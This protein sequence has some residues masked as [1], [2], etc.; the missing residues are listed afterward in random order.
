[1]LRTALFAI[2]LAVPLWAQTKQLDMQPGGGWIDTGI[3]LVPGDSLKITATGQMQYVN[4]RQ[5]NG[6]EGLSRGY[7]DLLRMMPFNDAGRGALIGRI[8]SNDAARPF[9]VGPTLTSRAPIAGRLFLAVNQSSSDSATG[10]YHISIERAAG[11]EAP[12]AAVSVT[13]FPQKM[14]D[15]IPKRVNDDNGTLGDRVN[16]ILIGSQDQVQAAL[17]A[18]GWVIV[19]TTKKEAVFSAI[20][21]SLSKDSYVTL[22]MSELNLFDRPQDFGYAQADPLTVVASRHHFRLWKTPY[23]LAGQLVWA[24]AGMHDIGF[25]RDQ[26]TNGV[27]HKIDPNSDGERDYIRDSLTQ[28]GLTV[29][30]DYITP[31]D[32]V[33]NATTA[34]GSP[35]TSDGRTLLVYFP[36]TAQ[37]AQQ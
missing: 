5:S 1:M 20:L 3:D 13:A 18:A 36:A 8:G 35:Y 30:T 37:T 6:P 19:D 33:R 28:T 25:D 31:T 27:T 29:K 2:L 32:P 34:T 17:K 26:R 15:S 7:M 16:F 21:A 12:R 14:I 4:A 10:A 11:T 9:V 24:G 23:T 22:P